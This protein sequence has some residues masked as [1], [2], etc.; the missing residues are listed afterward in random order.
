[1]SPPHVHTPTAPTPLWHIGSGTCWS[2]LG[3]AVIQPAV[4]RY[5]LSRAV[6]LT[7]SSSSGWSASHPSCYPLVGL[8]PVPICCCLLLLLAAWQCLLLCT[9][10]LPYPPA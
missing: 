2:R 6:A 7:P 5:I 3:G 8:G 4:Y 9:Y 1:M 10:R